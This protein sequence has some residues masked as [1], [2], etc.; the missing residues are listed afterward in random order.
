[1]MRSERSQQDIV[2]D[3]TRPIG[4][5]KAGAGHT[6]FIP[7]VIGATGVVFGDIGTSPLYTFNSIFTELHDDL[8]DKADV[9]QA[10]SVL[11]W[12]MVWMCCF[13]YIGLVMRVSHHGEGGTFAMMQVILEHIQQG[14][15]DADGSSDE[16]SSEEEIS[17]SQSHRLFNTS[18]REQ[19]MVLIL[20]L[21]SCSMLIGDGVVTP[22]NSVL[23]ALNSPVMNVDKNWNCIVA[24]LI[25]IFLFSL[26]RVG[27][28]FIG[29]VAGPVMIVWF[30]TMGALGVY[31]IVEN[32]ELASYMVQGFSPVKVYEFFISGRFRGFRAYKAI[33][34]VVLC[35]TGA[36][37]LYADMGHFGSRPITT[38]WF[39][40]VFPCL[41]LQYLG[42]A[43]V[44][45]KNPAGVEN[46]P[47]YQTVPD[48]SFLWPLFILAALA[49][50]IASQA[51][52]SGIF[53]LMSQAH[54]LGL[55]PRLLVLHTNPAEKGQACIIVTLAFRTSDN[56][57]AAYGIA[58]TGAFIFTTLLLFWV[59]WRVWGCNLCVVLLVVLPMITVDIVFW[60]AN[61]LKLLDSG[62]LPMAVAGTIFFLMHTHEWGRQ[63]EIAQQVQ[64]EEDEVSKMCSQQRLGFS[65]CT[66]QGLKNVLRQGQLLRTKSTAV[67]LT[68]R[69]GRVP[70]GLATIATK[71]GALPATIVLLHIEYCDEPFVLEAERVLFSAEDQSLGLWC[72]T[73]RFGYAEPLTPARFDLHSKLAAG[74]LAM[75][76]LDYG[77]PRRLATPSLTYEGNLELPEGSD[78]ADNFTYVVNRKLLVP[79]ADS[80]FCTRL[81]VTVYSL[82][83]KNSRSPMSTF[84]LEGQSVLEVAS[85]R[86]I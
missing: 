8:P 33:A 17:G 11:F 29:L 83:K 41:T 19:R 18:T 16:E 60:S 25:Q 35:V 9:Q 47:L 80:G 5:R 46:N 72:A 2:E 39:V 14:P 61:L 81:R 62:W 52:I 36:E 77:T 57:V 31:Q 50:V 51:L 74:E 43:I 68:P 75:Q 28:R 26:Q 54:A 24:V 10:F 59:L 69:A 73:F 15:K 23:G 66:L 6:G 21:L 71:L 65:V 40:M 42:Q 44:L 70:V 56:L 37:A 49:A 64:E 45:A 20:G 1:M 22:P 58:V 53:T 85:V 67:F 82:L 63:C 55:V 84:G 27:S 86:K 76:L 13:K 7:L 32:P 78:G 12:T 79:H 34:G 48:D 30:L 4:D 38:A 3:I